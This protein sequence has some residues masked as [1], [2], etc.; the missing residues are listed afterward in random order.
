[1]RH[2]GLYHSL[3]LVPARPGLVSKVVR[4]GK[5][6]EEAI[7]LGERIAQFSKPVTAICK[8]AVN[9]GTHR[10]NSAWSFLLPHTDKVRLHS[11]RVA[12]GHS[13]RNVPGRGPAL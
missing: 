3:L 11:H 8:E 13:V 9:A 4:D 2:L 12:A 7:R 10:I 6:V 5:V 1:M